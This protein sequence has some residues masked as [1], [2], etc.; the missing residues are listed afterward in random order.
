MRVDCSF[1]VL[2]RDVGYTGSSYTFPA[3]PSRET[4]WADTWVPAAETGHAAIGSTCSTSN[5]ASSFR[6]PTGDTDNAC[7][8]TCDGASNDVA[9]RLPGVA[10]VPLQATEPLPL[11]VPVPPVMVNSQPAAAVVPPPATEPSPRVTPVSPVIPNSQPAA[12]VV[13]PP[14]IAPLSWVAPV[15]PGILNSQPAVAVVPPPATAPLALVAPV[16]PGIL[17][18]QPAAAVVP[19]LATD[20]SLAPSGNRLYTPPSLPSLEDYIDFYSGLD[21]FSNSDISY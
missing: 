1:L 5:P 9:A 4:I 3:S 16:L 15:S 2:H 10:V 11:A 7:R 21:L 18:S 8:T 13:P 19:P 6:C 14:A 12:A 17:N 20:Q